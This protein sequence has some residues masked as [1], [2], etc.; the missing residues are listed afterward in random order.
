MDPLVANVFDPHYPARLRALA[1][2]P[3]RIEAR[4]PLAGRLDQLP[5]AVAI[6]GTR[7]ATQAGMRFTRWFARVVAERGM[8]VVSGGAMGIDTYAH[9]GAIAAGAP[10]VVVLPTGIDVRPDD[11]RAQLFEIAEANGAIVSVVEPT[12]NSTHDSNFSRNGVIAAIVDDVVVIEAPVRSGSRNT[13]KFARRLGRRLWVVPAS[14]F[15]HDR[16]GAVV[17]LLLGARPLV[18]PKPLLKLHRLDVKDLPPIPDCV[19]LEA[20]DAPSGETS[21]SNSLPRLF[22]PLPIC[23]T[24][25]ERR[26][27]QALQNGALSID[28]LVLL[29][30]LEVG[31]LRALLLTWTVDGVVREGPAGRF[32]LVSH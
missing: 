10:T 2:P 12:A 22:P 3:K 20:D 9:M 11:D 23:V 24:D 28:E 17:E 14:P 30:A 15:D 21:A 32:A 1:D 8:T 25:E 13:A 5:H 29:T 27:A 7:R 19:R 6:V 18:S 16:G 4:G 31:A 26:V